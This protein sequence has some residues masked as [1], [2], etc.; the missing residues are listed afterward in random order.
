LNALPAAD[1]ARPVEQ[2]VRDLE[3]SAER[4]LGARRGA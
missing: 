4:G 1:A 2:V 3:P